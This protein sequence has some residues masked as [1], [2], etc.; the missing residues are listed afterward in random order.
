MLKDPAAITRSRTSIF[1][2][3]QKKKN[4][5]SD[6]FGRI[7]LLLVFLYCILSPG[8]TPSR[9]KSEL[10]IHS[11][12]RL[13][14]FVCILSRSSSKNTYISILHVCVRITK[15][16]YVLFFLMQHVSWIIVYSLSSFGSLAKD[17]RTVLCSVWDHNDK[18]TVSRLYLGINPIVKCTW[19]H[20]KY[21]LKY[22]AFSWRV[23]TYGNKIAIFLF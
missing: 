9:Q 23:T 14:C 22:S 5:I 1:T 13:F 7:L 11:F 17:C 20:S 12:F 15:S 19:V 16:L 6:F 8:S 4:L 3:M 18:W 2:R 21:R 10:S